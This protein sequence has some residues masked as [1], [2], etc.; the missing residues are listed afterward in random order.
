M[1]IVVRILYD[2]I[3]DVC[4][5]FLDDL[6]IKGPTTRYDDEPYDQYPGLRKFIVEHIQ[7]ID[8]VLLNCELAGVTIA[9]KKSQ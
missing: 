3:S 8:R 6:C 2:L 5:A 1:R 7:N 4:R 9:A